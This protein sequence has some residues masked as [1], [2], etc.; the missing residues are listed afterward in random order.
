M[1]FKKGDILSYVHNENWVFRVVYS[2]NVRCQITSVIGSN[3]NGTYTHSFTD[4][5]F[6]LR[7]R[8]QEKRW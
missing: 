8:A 3:Y 4:E 5:N 2:D 6:D 1:T 7:S